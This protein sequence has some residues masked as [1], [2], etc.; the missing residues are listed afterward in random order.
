MRAVEAEIGWMYETRHSDGRPGRINYTVWSEV[1]ACPEC[2][3]E[4]VFLE[5]ALD[6]ETQ[7][8]RKEFP[9]PSC[10]ATLTKKRLHRLWE[11]VIDPVL[12]S[13]VRHTRRR[14]IFINYSVGGS[15]YEKAPGEADL[16]LLQRIAALPFPPDFPTDRMMHAPEDVQRWGDNWRAGTANFSHVHHLFLPRPTQAVALIS[17]L[18]AKVADTRERNILLF[19]AEQVVWSISI[20]NRYAPS[21]YSQ[22]SRYMSGLIRVLS[23]HAECSPWYILEGKLERLSA[24]FQSG[25]AG[26]GRAMVSTGSATDLGLPDNCIDYVFTDPPFGDNLAYAE[27]NF[28][29]ESFHRVFTNAE[30]EAVVNETQHKGLGDYQALMIRCFAEYHRMLKP[31]RWMTVVFHNSR[32]SVWNAIQQA[33]QAVGFVVADVRVLDKRQ[34][35]FNQAVAVNSVKQDLVISAYKPSAEF[36]QRF[37]LTAGTEAG[38]WEFVRSHLAKLSRFIPLKDRQAEVITERMNYMLFDRMVAYHLTKGSTVPLSAAEFYAGLSQRFD[39]RE[40]MYFLP[41]QVAEYMNKRKTVEELRQLQFFVNNEASAIQW[42]RQQFQKKPQTAKELNPQFMK[43]L[44]GWEAHERPL[45]LLQLLEQSFLCYDGT[46]AVPSQIHSY[47]STNFKE[48]RG[49]GK[50]DPRLVERA[51]DRW[52][53]PDPNRASD[54]EKLRERALLR[55]FESYLDPKQKQLRLFRLEAV[56]AGFHKAWQERDYATILLVAAKLPHS[57]LSE[58][59]KLMRWYDLARIRTGETT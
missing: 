10:R 59:G 26:V 7:G 42:L 31:G 12:G 14:P 30:P 33:L 52:Y 29:L 32:N 37:E 54:L 6:S 13:P 41:D 46:G 23:Q 57:V 15:R 17:R 36:E 49:L 16:A 27:L 47:L 21:H 28:I 2:G 34:G 58:D 55:E 18:V 43:Q 25:Y 38:V 24:T 4:V 20:L 56:R 5:E 50:E 1:F 53:V 45:E 44:A 40:G 3:G 9:C 19:F 8:V 48:L 11:T 22:V 35:S 39:E 51:R